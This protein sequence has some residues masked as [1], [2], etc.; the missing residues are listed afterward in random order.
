[1]KKWPWFLMS[2]CVIGLDQA[3]K[4]LAQAA[5]L[6]M[7]PVAICPMLNFHLAFNS[8]AAF[9]FLSAS[10]DWHRW[11]FGLFSAVMSLVI[12]VWLYRLPKDERM[13]AM[14]LSLILGGAVGNL[15]DRMRY[16]HVIDFIDVYYQY[17]HWPVFNLADSA[18][19]LGAVCL[20]IDM[21]RAR[22]A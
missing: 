14:G 3:S 7:R 12:A 10:G 17:H 13:Q 2:L 1:M 16:G 22:K 18:I 4:I 20:F 15:I 11:F 6:P 9:S 5:L 8:G 21:L 19:T